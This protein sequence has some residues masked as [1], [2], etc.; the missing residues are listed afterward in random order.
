[1]ASD[2]AHASVQGKGELTQAET[3]FGASGALTGREALLANLGGDVLSSRIKALESQRQHVLAER[4]LLQ[5]HWEMRSG[6][7]ID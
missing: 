5:R 2:H 6:N 1:M 7:R 3:G 4:K